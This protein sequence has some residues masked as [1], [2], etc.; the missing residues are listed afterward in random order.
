MKIFAHRGL[1]LNYPENTILSFTHALEQGFGLEIDIHRTKDGKLVVI[2]DSNLKRLASIDKEITNINFDSLQKIG[3]NYIKATGVN[4]TG[5]IPSLRET[6][7]L[8]RAKSL[9]VVELAIQ[10]KDCSEKDIEILIVKELDQFE[11]IFQILTFI[12]VF[13]CLTF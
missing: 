9:P 1:M 8:F 11:K 13:L 4:N 12:N 3:I 2:H 10:V 5:K 7:E 6:L